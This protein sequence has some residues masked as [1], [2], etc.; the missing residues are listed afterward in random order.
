[1]AIASISSCSH[2]GKI[3]EN[4][5][6]RITDLSSLGWDV[7]WPVVQSE[8]VSVKPAA[9]VA[10]V[11]SSIWNACYK[12]M[13]L[14]D[15]T[16]RMLRDA[17]TAALSGEDTFYGRF[18]RQLQLDQIEKS[19]TKQYIIN[20]ISA[21][22]DGHPH[23]GPSIRDITDDRRLD[24]V[25]DIY[26]YG[27]DSYGNMYCLYKLYTLPDSLS[28]L[29]PSD[30]SY[31]FKQSTPGELW[32]RLK[33][34]PLAFPAFSG[35][36]PNVYVGDRKRHIAFVNLGGLY[37]TDAVGRISCD[38][39]GSAVQLYGGDAVAYSPSM[40]CIYDFEFVKDHDDVTFITQMR[41]I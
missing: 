22:W 20:Q 24:D 41:G 17:V 25:Y 5:A 18:Y 16:A 15:V 29:S 1:M 31:R 32:I 6:A 19:E 28:A 26:R 36:Y 3:A 10:A 4:L 2:N 39:Y 38:E 33:D 30:A 21:Y 37:K 9:Q 13:Q 35:K 8:L 34:H 27:I 11:S 40:S 12:D 7:V 23:K 14:S